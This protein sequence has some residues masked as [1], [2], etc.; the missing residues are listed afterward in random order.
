MRTL[1]TSTSLAAVLA[2][3]S[4]SALAAQD[5][6]SGPAID[7]EVA[8]VHPATVDITEWDVEWEES[9]PRDPYVAPDGTIW[10]VGQR[11]HYVATLDPA[12]GE[13]ERIDLVDGAGPHTVIADENGAW[14]AGNRVGHIGFIDGETHEI[15]T[16]DLPGEGPND[17]HTMDFDSQGNIWFTVQGGNQIGYLDVASREV[18]AWDVE[19]EGARP[20]GILVDGNDQPWIVLFGTNKLAT[21]ENG[22]VREI[23]L[24]REE[25]RPRRMAITEDGQIWY[26][27]YAD[28]YLGRYNPDSEEIDEWRTPSAGEAAP[29][30]MTSDGDGM[31]WFVESGPEPN[32]FVG[33]DPATETFT[34]PVAVPSGGGT[35]RHMV[36]D[37]AANAIWFGADTNTIGRATIQSAR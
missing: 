29:Y 34:E 6:V 10:F 20:Y 9:R 15:E 7:A 16:I 33:F 19:T 26:V 21:V 18:E 23:N 2:L 5:A 27:D 8:A 32:L 12:T 30:A 36:F 22:A 3:A 24:P 35:V 17:V 31:L 28:G 13:M 14:Y 25:T 11:S 4:A 37:P 1:M